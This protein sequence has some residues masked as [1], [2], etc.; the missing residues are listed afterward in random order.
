M[1]RWEITAMDGTKINIDADEVQFTP[2]GV[3]LFI[4][5]SKTVD[6]GGQ[7]KGELVGCVG[8]TFKVV[9]QITKPLELANI[10]AFKNGVVNVSI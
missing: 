6:D 5:L 8:N 2:S 10:D 3:A 7:A 4:N 1:K 9:K